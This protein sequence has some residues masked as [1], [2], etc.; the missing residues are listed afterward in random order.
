MS[1]TTVVENGLPFLNAPPRHRGGEARHEQELV[2]L[3][4]LFDA[5]VDEAR[6]HAARV[7]CEKLQK[8]TAQLKAVRRTSTCV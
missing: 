5:Q 1:Q 6:A 8:T 2:R 7:A 3:T 4:Q